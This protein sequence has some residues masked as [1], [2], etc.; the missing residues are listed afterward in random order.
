MI[1]D[2]L[3][4]IKHINC[5]LSS[6]LNNLLNE[7]DITFQQ[8]HVILY[9]IKHKDEDINQKRIEKAF[10]LKPST[11]SGIIDRLRNKGFISKNKVENDGRNNYLF[12]TEKGLNLYDTLENNRKYINSEIFKDFTLEEKEKLNIYLEKMNDNLM[13][14][15]KEN[16][17]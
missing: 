10:G 6:N 16:N 7:Y 9:L 3:F 1:K 2:E 17:I 11:V 4:Y 15:G 13:N 5:L 8:S 12:V 14:I